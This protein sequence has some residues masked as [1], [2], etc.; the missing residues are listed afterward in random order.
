MLDTHH[1]LSLCQFSTDSH[2]CTA[3]HELCLCLGV[4][5]SPSSEV[6]D[7][8]EWWW[9]FGHVT[10]RCFHLICESANSYCKLHHFRSHLR[11]PEEQCTVLL[12]VPHCVRADTSNVC[13][14]KSRRHQMC[15]NYILA[16]RITPGTRGRVTVCLLKANWFCKVGYMNIF[17]LWFTTS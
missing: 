7:N 12:L 17:K 10:S 14:V 6:C 13:R 2:H 8:D 3:V 16:V 5:T 15:D 11:Q 9:S 4:N 1:W